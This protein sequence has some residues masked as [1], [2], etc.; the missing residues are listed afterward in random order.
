MR[1]DCC[2]HCFCRRVWR[3]DDTWY[4]SNHS[5]KR[6]ARS[7]GMSQ[8]LI[9]RFPSTRPPS[10][11]HVVT[12]T[13]MVQ[14][15]NYRKCVVFCWP[16]SP[17]ELLAHPP[18]VACSAKLMHAVRSGCNFFTLF[19]SKRDC[20][21]ACLGET[22]QQQFLHPLCSRCGSI[23]LSLVFLQ[24]AM[25]PAQKRPRVGYEQSA[26]LF[27]CTTPQPDG[28]LWPPKLLQLVVNGDKH[29]VCCD[30]SPPHG[31][32]MQLPDTLA[33]TFH[34]SGGAKV[35]TSVFKPIE[36]TDAWLQTN[37]GPPWQGVLIP[38]AAGTLQR[39]QTTKGCRCVTC[40]IGLESVRI[41]YVCI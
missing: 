34:H 15:S 20:D 24:S 17:R 33:I 19:F 35:K 6:M 37:A 14:T 18:A 40:S 1:V 21:A 16:N 4:H 25:E 27:Q 11:I 23:V 12:R 32:W 9:D 3:S 13:F 5:H 2:R 36:G 41:L 39:M 8:S 22:N 30:H 29:E 38:K 10:I 28:S 31:T 7:F 26:F